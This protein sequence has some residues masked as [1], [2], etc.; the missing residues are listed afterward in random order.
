MRPIRLLFYCDDTRSAP[1]HISLYGRWSASGSDR[2]IAHFVIA[3]RNKIKGVGEKEQ[4]NNMLGLIQAKGEKLCNIAFPMCI[5][6]LTLSWISSEIS[7]QLLGIPT[8]LDRS[9]FTALDP[10][11]CRLLTS[12]V[13][14]RLATRVTLRQ[15]P[16]SQSLCLTLWLAFPS[17]FRSRRDLESK[18]FVWFCAKTDKGIVCLADYL[19]SVTLKITVICEFLKWWKN[20]NFMC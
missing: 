11:S 17:Y 6:R 15:L 16:S 13:R 12:A 19:H 3:T 2:G 8:H 20:L 4:T 18:P 7:T 9:S 14:C 10:I 5:C 1:R